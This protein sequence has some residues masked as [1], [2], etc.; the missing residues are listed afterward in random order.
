MEMVIAFS[1]A[2][3]GAAALAGLRSCTN[4]LDNMSQDGAANPEALPMGQKLDKS[5]L[6]K[7]KKLLK[8]KGGMQELL[9]EREGMN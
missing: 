7:L 6:E 5:R 4:H 1:V 8:Q 2:V 3:L 9:K